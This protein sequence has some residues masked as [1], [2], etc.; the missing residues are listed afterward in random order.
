MSSSNNFRVDK[1]VETIQSKDVELN[2]EKSTVATSVEKNS[3]ATSTE[4]LMNYC[5]TEVQ[6]Q[7]FNSLDWEPD[8]VDEPVQGLNVSPTY[9]ILIFCITVCTNLFESHVIKNFFS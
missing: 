2:K 8:V 5:S 1:A 6:T 7:P 3:T 4:Q 9:F